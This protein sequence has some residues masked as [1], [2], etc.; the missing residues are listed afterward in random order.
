MKKGLWVQQNIF[1]FGYDKQWHYADEI[2]QIDSE[3]ILCKCKCSKHISRYLS[4]SLV[5][6]EMPPEDFNIICD[7][8]HDMFIEEIVDIQ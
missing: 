2:F 8:I 5:K 4:S 1:I 6:T 7:S 3:K